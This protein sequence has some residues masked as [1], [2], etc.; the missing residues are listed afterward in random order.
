MLSCSENFNNIMKSNIRPRLE[1]LIVVSGYGINGE[2]V[3]L[4]WESSELQ[5]IKW[6]RSIDPTGNE[7]PCIELQWTEIYMDKLDAELGIEKY[8]Q[9]LPQ[10]KVELFWRQAISAEETWRA[11]YDNNITWGAL[12]DSRKT[13]DNV[14]PI[15][16]IFTPT[17]FL[18]SKPTIKDNVI[19]WTAVDI[20]AFADFEHK[21]YYSAGNNITIKN[22]AMLMLMDYRA[23]VWENMQ[24]RDALT[25][26]IGNIDNL[27]LSEEENVINHD[28]IL[29]GKM[30]EN[31]K[32][33]LASR[34]L[35]L[36]FDNFGILIVK[37]LE[38]RN[39]DFEINENI[40]HSYPTV[41]LLNS[42]KQYNCKEYLVEK[43]TNK[44]YDVTASES[45][46]VDGLA[47][48]RYN[49]DGDG[50]S[51]NEYSEIN[52]DIEVQ[53][54]NNET[55]SVVPLKTNSYDYSYVDQT[56]KNG[57]AITE[58]NPTIPFDVNHDIPFGRI[59]YLRKFQKEGFALLEANFLGHPA[60]SVGDRVTIPTDLFDDNGERIT[61]DG[62]VQKFVFEYKGYSNEKITINECEEWL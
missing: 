8:R 46:E 19:T 34:N 20:L 21:K 23:N 58:K 2:Y 9:I 52:Y 44:S 37:R 27:E 40:L 22:L 18:K 41:T 25:N 30:K 43:N 6:T 32:N 29:N 14:M 59:R 26:S 55:I 3:T 39:V 4:T 60:L 5:S 62:F 57:D 12:Y 49:F 7:L 54:E 35:F 45:Y 33:L 28:L 42:I 1:A 61:K 15:E 50:V 51:E 56:L 53:N 36:D 48:Y 47:L 17:L 38:Q 24:M 11:L 13:W 16:Q 10:M 31:L